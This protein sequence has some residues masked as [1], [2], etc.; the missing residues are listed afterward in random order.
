[1]GQSTTGDTV[2]SGTFAFLY[3]ADLPDFGRNQLPM[4]GEYCRKSG[5]LHVRLIQYD[6]H[7]VAV[8]LK[9]RNLQAL[10]Q[11][12]QQKTLRIVQPLGGLRLEETVAGIY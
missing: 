9:I 12:L 8:I 2:D 10:G 7:G 6:P 4:G 11:S 3:W 1:M 5:M